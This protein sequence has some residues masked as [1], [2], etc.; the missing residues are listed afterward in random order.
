MKRMMC[1]LALLPALA[2]AAGRDD[3]ARQWPLTLQDGDAGAYRVTLGRDVYRNAV[4]PTLRDVAVFNGDGQ[5][6][7]A[8][9]FDPEQPLARAARAVELPWFPLPPGEALPAQDIAVI[10]E[11]DAQG[12]V[13]RVET[14]MADAAQAPTRA[15][16]A[17]L[18]DASAVRE[19]I[20]ALLLEWPPSDAAIDVAYR[21]DGS[22]NLRDWRT[23]QPHVQLLDLVR[24]GQRLRQQRIALYGNAKY[25]RLSPLRGDAAL[26]LSGVRAEFATKATAS[27][28]EWESLQG[29]AV[30]ESGKTHYDFT[31]DGRFPFARADIDTAGNDAN[32]WTL[33]SRDDADAPW[34]TRAGPWVAFQVG[35]QQVGSGRSAP[36]ELGSVIR[37]R[38]WRLSSRSPASGAP[39]LKLGYRPEVVVFLAQGKP[40]YA[41]TAGSA[42]AARADAPLPQLIDSLRAQRGRDWQPA[43]ATLGAMQTLAGERALAPKR[44]WTSWLLWSLLVAGAIVVAGFAIS[45]LRGRRGDGEAV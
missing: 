12:R 31:I 35:T 14:R 19:P 22:D 15:A 23:L 25:L 43:S 8:A 29:R 39:T 5:P 45:L 38:H 1:V 7:P 20:A 32:E 33:Q 24:S 6:V 30:E 44:D 26:P 10:S 34:I 2:L 16:N 17:W 9:L 4:S 21:I 41:L 27:D 40:P 28:W 42:Q 36:Q 18:I 37:D 13:R 11:R 3:Y